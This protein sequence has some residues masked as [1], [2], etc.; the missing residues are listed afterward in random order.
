V[1]NTLSVTK[2][3]TLTNGTKGTANNGTAGE[4][5]D[6]TV[7]VG[8]LDVREQEIELALNGTL[9]GDGAVGVQFDTIDIARGS[10]LAVTRT[11]NSDDYTFNILNVHGKYT[12]TGSLNADAKNALTLNFYPSPNVILNDPDDSMLHVTGT[13]NITDG[14]TLTLAD[15]VIVGDAPSLQKGDKI[16]LLTADG[17]LTDDSAYEGQSAGKL[18][19]GV[20]LVADLVWGADT[21]NL[22]AELSSLM[23]ANPQLEVVSEGFL[24]GL[25]LIN[26]GT[27]L[28]LESV[29]ACAEQ[30][31]AMRAAGT[32]YCAFGIASGGTL[33]TGSHGAMNHFSATTGLS[34]SIA[35][36]PGNL[37]L[38]AFFEYGDGTYRTRGTFSDAAPVRGHGSAHYAGGGLLARLDLTPTVQGRA[39]LEAS[40]RAG[41]IDNDYRNPDMVAF[42]SDGTR[43]EAG[44]KIDVPYVGLYAGAG[45]V[46][47]LPNENALELSG[48]YFWTHQEGKSIHLYT[49]E[50]IR[51]DATDS[52]RVRA[53]LR[54]THALDKNVSVYAGLAYEHEFDA[55]V[56]AKVHRDYA[57]TAPDVKGGTGSGEIGLKMKPTHS[58]PLTIDLSLRGYAGK[59][60]GVTGSLRVK[61]EF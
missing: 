24:S 57:V 61:W 45:Y 36:A 8:T 27:D 42:L 7:N 41:R 47:F 32:E 59:R 28:L 25:M 49:N 37:A 40:A 48:K 43:R 9:A 39:Y 6:L 17:G 34:K 14:S 46:L 22:F 3:L 56:R 60:E 23:R 55:E 15:V 50:P 20:G 18:R 13:A 11:N 30:S 31:Q 1:T 29:T 58:R 5:G 52:H 12:D 53:G 21:N 26:Q 44:F 51:F 54:Y 38:G 4:G 35:L 33:H 19:Q 16:M 10:T 2:K